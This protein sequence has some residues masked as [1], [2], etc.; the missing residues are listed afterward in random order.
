MIMKKI[1]S[2][3]IT[4]SML[5]LSAA[6]VFAI[7]WT[8]P[9]IPFEPLAK[10]IAFS[11]R[12]AAKLAQALTDAKFFD[13]TL[14]TEQF[15]D[16][17]KNENNAGGYAMSGTFKQGGTVILD[18]LEYELINEDGYEIRRVKLDHGYYIDMVFIS[19]PKNKKTAYGSSAAY[20]RNKDGYVI[21]EI[22]FAARFA[23]NGK[24]TKSTSQTIQGRS[25][26]PQ[27]TFSDKKS[28]GGDEKPAVTVANASIALN[29]KDSA[30]KELGECR[31]NA[32]VTCDIYGNTISYFSYSKKP[33]DE[34]PL[35]NSG[36]YTSAP[37]ASVHFYSHGRP[38]KYFK[39]ITDFTDKNASK[40]AE[41]LSLADYGDYE[42][43]RGKNYEIK[44]LNLKHGYKMD[45]VFDSTN[46]DLTSDY[47]Y[48]KSQDACTPR[49]PALNVYIVDPSGHYL[50]SMSI[51]AYFYAKTEDKK[52]TTEIAAHG[53]SA[54]SG[55]A[56]ISFSAKKSKGA[57]GDLSSIVD[58]LF[59]LDIKD[60]AKTKSF[61]F[62]L[63]IECHPG[64]I[65]TAWVK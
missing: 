37:K 20:I 61:T 38:Y 65:V 46:D 6:G 14:T 32:Q 25:Y 55:V 35:E 22:T 28:G 1:I 10:N 41:A 62:N 50:A 11:D 49:N 13:D 39:N 8:I 16:M 7:D 45:I 56:L 63:Q 31:Y 58:G 27:I 53:A 51:F 29:I 34:I 44:R 40:L 4:L 9:E 26:V 33:D 3:A 30:K 42:L 15:I 21:A 19:Q 23:Y 2:L 52:S 18:C 64:G 48:N 5:F 36:Y 17:L 12:D 43:I 60:G 59:A 24:K 47:S 57:E 54:D